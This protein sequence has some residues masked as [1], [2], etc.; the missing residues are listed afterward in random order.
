MSSLCWIE[1]P[2]RADTNQEDLVHIAYSS[3]NFRDVMLTTG[4]LIT[5]TTIMC[6]RFDENIIGLEYVGI[7]TAGRRVMGISGN[8]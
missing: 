5:D 3:I 8:R 4:K 6:S 7:D 2:I 1:G